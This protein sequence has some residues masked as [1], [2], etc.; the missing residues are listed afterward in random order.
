MYR[1]EVGP[2][3]ETV[4]RTIEELAVGIRNG[5]IT[6]RAR[7]YHHASQ[8]WLPIGLHPH[9]KKALELP[10]ATAASPFAPPSQPKAQAPEPKH[11]PAPRHAPESRHVP[12]P[13][14]APQPKI[15]PE[16]RPRPTAAAPSMR[17]PVPSPVI[18]MQ[19]EVL[20]DLPVIPIPE[21]GPLPWGAPTATA[22]QAPEHAP[23]TYS[24]R[25]LPE[26]FTPEDHEEPDLTAPRPTARRSHRA[27]GR[28]LL[29]LGAAAA[30]VAGTHL[31]L[32]ATPPASRATDAPAAVAADD[33]GED[34]L[35]VPEAT[36]DQPSDAGVQ[37]VTSAPARVVM[38]PGPAFSGSVPTR[39]VPD[40]AP[41]RST[42]ALAPIAAGA[43]N[44]ADAPAIAPV[45]APVPG[46]IDLALPDLGADP[47][48]PAT[49]RGDTLGMKKILR[50][51]NA[52]SQAGAPIRP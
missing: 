52:P 2:G 22:V 40:S 5:V 11:T 50:A 18:A 17:P 16:P 31:A 39:G 45:I 49:R 38:T 32:T 28:P 35:E 47:V 13:K 6:P 44:P 9:Y 36:A 19:Q 24:P 20:R 34:P 48:V 41:G 27:G 3:E 42:S 33:D 15:I 7:I 29:L 37:R 4:F 1:I 30:L 8:K 26:P 51:L 46:A 10:A 14:V 25:E 12:E 21:P 23:V 43:S